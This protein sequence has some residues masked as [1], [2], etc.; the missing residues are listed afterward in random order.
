MNLIVPKTAA[1]EAL[2]LTLPSRR[3]EEWKWTDLRRLVDTAYV[4]DAQPK[5]DLAAVKRQI[6]ASPFAKAV[7]HRI[8]MVNGIYEPKLSKADGIKVSL[9]QAA[10]PVPDDVF[11]MAN[12]LKPQGVALRFEGA[13]DTPVEIIHVATKGAPRAIALHNIIDVG[14]GANA[15][16][17]ETFVGEGDYLVLSSTAV[18]VGAGGR[19]DRIK[20]ERESSAATHLAT[21][22]ITLAKDS[23]LRDF[24]L[25]AGSKLNRQN[26]TC[27]FEGENGDAKISGTYLLDGKQHADT[28]LIIDHQVPHCTSRELFKCVLDDD[29]RGIFQGKVIVRKHAQKT[30]GKQSSNALLLSPR[31]EFDAKPELE[32]YADDVVCGHGA[33]AGDLDHDHMFYLRSRGIP[34]AEAKKLLVEAFA[35][36]AFDTV[37]NEQ[38][39]EA[40]IAIVHDR[41]E[42]GG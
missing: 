4:I 18:T 31:A 3:L 20:A 8:V 25:T 40:L 32:I 23:I 12:N 30:D 42:A 19:L 5:A 16:I 7:Q 1:E 36:E 33:T 34:E 2:G 10:F 28:R 35:S 41:M 26:G 22:A 29:A 38:L 6:E 9:S 39:R 24:T 21:N 27:T 15:T 37:E 14:D 11:E 13:V 17:V